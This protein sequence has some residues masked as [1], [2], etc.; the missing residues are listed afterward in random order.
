[1][2]EKDKKLRDEWQYWESSYDRL[3]STQEK[4]SL[5]LKSEVSYIRGWLYK[6][7]GKEPSVEDKVLQIGAGPVDVIDFWDSNERYA[8]DPLAEEYKEEFHDFQ[9]QGVNYTAGV[10]EDLPYEDNYFDIVIIRNA[11]DHVYGPRKTLREIHRVLKPEGSLYIWV[12]LY[13]WRGSLAY[14]A[15]NALTKRY[16]REPWA[17]TWGR[18]IRLL[19]KE[20]F[21]LLYPAREKRPPGKHKNLSIFTAQGFNEVLRKI[22]DLNADEGFICVTRPVK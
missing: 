20:R 18:I 17:F 9:D 6:A 21:E 14:R 1:M 5:W 12:Y 10:G 13:S 15:I 16:E 2:P 22:L 11:L 3:I 4:R 8:I 19:K 7:T